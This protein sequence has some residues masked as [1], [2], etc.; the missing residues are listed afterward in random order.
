V[1][2]IGFSFGKRGPHRPAHQGLETVRYRQRNEAAR[3]PDGSMTGEFSD[4]MRRQATRA[5]QY[6]RIFPFADTVSDSKC[7][8]LANLSQADRLRLQLVV[9]TGFLLPA[10]APIQKKRTQ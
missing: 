8:L 4:A 9:E 1:V 6:G 7:K 5:F 10:N 2:F 3:D